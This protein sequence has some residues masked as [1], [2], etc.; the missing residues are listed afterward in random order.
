MVVGYTKWWVPIGD[1]RYCTR[2]RSG[3]W[4]GLKREMRIR[5]SDSLGMLAKDGRK[6]WVISNTI[7]SEP[8]L[9]L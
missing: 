7:V 5:L 8:S 4:R 6:S 1:D 2:S 9:N 3:F